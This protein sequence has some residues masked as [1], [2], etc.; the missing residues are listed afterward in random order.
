MDELNTTEA[1]EIDW[2]RRS[3]I[4]YSAP[5]LVA[6]ERAM[7]HRKI[8]QSNALFYIVCFASRQT[9]VTKLMNE[10]KQFKLGI[11]TDDTFNLLRSER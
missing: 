9:Q 11:W 8:N 6:S 3:G 4:I 2:H 7:N 5:V 1:N 10:V